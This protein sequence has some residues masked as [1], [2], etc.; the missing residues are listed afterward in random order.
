MDYPDSTTAPSVEF[1]SSNVLRVPK[2]RVPA[3]VV[4]VDHTIHSGELYA[5]IL[6][7]DGSPGRILDRLV[8]S[9]EK[10]LPL[11]TESEHILLSKAHILL[12]EC[13]SDEVDVPSANGAKTLCVQLRLVTGLVLS[14][15]IR[16][17]LPPLHARVLDYLNAISPK[18]ITTLQ[19]ENATLVNA[20]HVVS[21][22]EIIAPTSD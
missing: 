22:A 19:D 13:S 17:C 15:E 6:R 20:S 18:F 4:L 10:Y 1:K 8:D 3:R 5:D 2:R 21:V 7:S 11:A 14:G 9:T 16:T 12:V